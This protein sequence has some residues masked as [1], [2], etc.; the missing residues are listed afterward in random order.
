[1]TLHICSHHFNDA[2]FLIPTVVDASSDVHIYRTLQRNAITSIY[3]S[4]TFG[5][6]KE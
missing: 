5:K 1:M 2:D 6:V 3:L 4:P